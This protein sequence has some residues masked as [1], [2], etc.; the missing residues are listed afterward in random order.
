MS[1]GSKRHFIIKKSI[2]NYR[3]VRIGEKM[4]KQLLYKAA[5]SFFYVAGFP[6]MLVMMLIT[7]APMFNVE[8]MGNYAANWIIVFFVLWAVFEA[9]RFVLNRFVGR[10]S[11]R[12]QKVVVVA[13]AVFAILLVL[14]PSAIFDAVNR[15][16]YEEDYAS[17]S[18]ATDVK[19][20]DKVMGW[21]RDFTTKYESE[22]YYLINDHYDFMKQYGLSHTYSEWFGN[23][24]KENG[25][26][27]K[28][29]SFEKIDQLYA[30]KTEAVGLLAA[31][32]QELAAIE[33]KQAELTAAY[34]AAVESGVE[35]DITAAKKALDDYNASVDADLIRLKGER[36]DIS[37]I[38]P[39]LVK[40]L[41]TVV[42]DILKGGNSEILNSD[43]TI[44]L[45]G[46]QIP[47]KGIIDLILSKIPIDITGFITEEMLSGLIP[48]V[49]YT[50]L[51]AETVST[52]ETMV[53]G[54]GLLSDELSLAQVES[55]RFRMNH[56][57]QI[58]AAGA[59]KYA[60]YIFVGIIV[61]CI[62][63]ADYFA[64]KEK[65]AKGG[66]FDE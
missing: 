1:F 24:D 60:A 54:G 28:V 40:V 35:A 41:Y 50:G 56:Y 20:Y 37:A 62:F 16:K 45:I 66:E 14:L 42:Q 43:W 34:E 9:V 29:G 10:R 46:Q 36:L 47:V 55:L 25:L 7:L 58:M 3:L 38:K 4:N 32:Q 8:V 52:Y 18:A 48:D 57:P 64:R 39:E 51:G 30:E 6:M 27:Y 2:I 59:V 5:K 13:T 31:A 49:I 22:V 26:G 61:F 11:E 17:L 65:Q 15:P 44:E 12:H 23:A 33:A 21:H 19:S 63:A 53:N